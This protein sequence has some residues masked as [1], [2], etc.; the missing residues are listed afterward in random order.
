VDMWRINRKVLDRQLKNPKNGNV[1]CKNTPSESELSIVCKQDKSY[2][3][4]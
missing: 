3:S 4:S 1:R 2:E